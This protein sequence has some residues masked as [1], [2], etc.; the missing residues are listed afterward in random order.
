MS[1]SATPWIAALQAP[2]PS[3]TPRVHSDSRPSKLSVNSSTACLF[4]SLAFFLQGS[5]GKESACLSSTAAKNIQYSIIFS[6]LSEYIFIPSTL[7]SKHEHYVQVGL[8]QTQKS[9]LLTCHS[10]NTLQFGIILF[11]L[12]CL[13]LYVTIQLFH[14]YADL[15]EMGLFKRHSSSFPSWPTNVGDWSGSLV[16]VISE[17]EI[18]APGCTH[19]Q[20]STL[21]VFVF[22][23]L[24]QTTWLL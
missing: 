9:D 10:L 3:P 24:L 8:F 18:S 7:W 21:D 15:A 20:G 16:L 6:D 12:W 5:D 1:D 22:L 17:T 19:W 23:L 11:K 2:C 13:E 14:H 4:Y